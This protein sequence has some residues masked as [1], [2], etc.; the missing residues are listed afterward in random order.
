MSTDEDFVRALIRAHGIVD[1]G[2]QVV[3]LEDYLALVPAARER[4]ARRTNNGH[5]WRANLRPGDVWW[6]DQGRPGVCTVPRP[7]HSED[8]TCSRGGCD[9]VLRYTDRENCFCHLSAPCHYCMEMHLHCPECDWHDDG[10]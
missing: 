5:G 9:G 10:K 6:I 1:Y 8:S 2:D 7:G 3:T 4:Q